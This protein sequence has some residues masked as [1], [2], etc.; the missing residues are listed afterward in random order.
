MRVRRARFVLFDVED[1]RHAEID[2]LLGG[3]LAREPPGIHALA[4]LTGQR[5]PLTRAEFAALAAL[6]SGD[7]SEPEDPA[8]ARSL[9]ARGLLV[10]DSDEEPFAR[11]RARDDAL[12]RDGWNLYAAGHHFMTQR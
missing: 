9:A 1:A 2:A 6:P 3:E 12:L 10:A 8:L 11:L 4:L 7:W 5:E